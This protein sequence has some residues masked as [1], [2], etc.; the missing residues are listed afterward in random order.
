M[1]GRPSKKQR[2]VMELTAEYS[3]L[4]GYLRGLRAGYPDLTNIGLMVKRY[5]LVIGKFRELLSLIEEDDR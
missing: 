5:D 1:K 4:G 2:L 3:Y